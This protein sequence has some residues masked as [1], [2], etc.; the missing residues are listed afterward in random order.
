MTRPRNESRKLSG[1]YSQ[2]DFNI[3]TVTKR[4]SKDKRDWGEP[5]VGTSIAASPP[6]VVPRPPAYSAKEALPGVGSECP[7]T[8][9]GAENVI[10]IIK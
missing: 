3:L 7:A 1:M 10:F 8:V 2:D 4:S 6:R 9:D 5:P